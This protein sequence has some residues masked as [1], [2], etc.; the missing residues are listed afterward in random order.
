MH[1][2]DKNTEMHTQNWW[3]FAVYTHSL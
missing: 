3:S 2:I 1:K